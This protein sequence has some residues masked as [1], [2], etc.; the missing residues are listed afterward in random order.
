V[1]PGF[2]LS[3]I[4]LAAFIVVR[5]RKLSRETLVGG[6]LVAAGC[7]AV[8]TG[9]V[10]LPDFE[11]LIEDVGKALGTWTYLLVGALAFLETGAFIGLIAPGETAV[12]VGG[13]VAA[14]GEVN[15]TVLIAL[16]WTCAVAGDLTSFMLGRKLGRQFLVKH[17]PRMHITEDRIAW[18]EDFFERHGGP[19]ILI[20][21]FVGLVRALAPF[22]AGASGM[23]LRRFLP[24]DVVGAGLWASLFCLLGFI[25]WHSLDRVTQY[26]GQGVFLLGT[27]VAL[28]V[29]VMFVRR[30]M[31]DPAY[32]AKVKAWLH[33]QAERPWLRPLASVAFPAYR[34]LGRPFLRAISGPA[35]FLYERLTPGQLGLELTTLLALA[36]VGGYTVFLL[37]D[38]ISEGR[39]LLFLD[40]EALDLAHDLYDPTVADVV[41]GIT[42]LGALPIA[43]GFTLG[44]AIWAAAQRRVIE[45]VMLVFSLATTWLA[46]DIAK[47]LEDRSRPLDPLV[48]TEG[49]AFPSGHAAY[50]VAYIACAV[51]LARQD[52]SFVGR[53]S[54]VTVAVV[55]CVAIA[56]SRVYLRA[57]YLS[58]VVGGVAMAV[59]IFAIGGMVAL[60]ISHVRQNEAP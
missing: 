27:I 57:H 23:P 7:A 16:V 5:R 37:G 44:T 40:R 47:Q 26:V 15:I 42:F 4:A 52:G 41:K 17:G 34:R 43:F 19:T 45:A 3:A 8:G 36:V 20:G 30:V 24:Y 32:K 18:V 22:I 6:A 25:F 59:M 39:P 46:V 55:L 12:L 2:L 14:Q 21:R 31:R 53:L 54:A 60:I 38:L 48:G 49:D 28:V 50:G 58:D 9:L 29:G 1:R 13:V 51:V 11:K 56:L 10:E 35:R 33:E